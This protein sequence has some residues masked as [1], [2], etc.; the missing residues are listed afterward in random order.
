MLSYFYYS[1]AANFATFI[2]QIATKVTNF[3]RNE[4][5]FLGKFLIF[6]AIFVIIVANI[7]RHLAKFATRS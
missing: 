1:K 4:Q 7:A 2:V 6:L 5:K 3:A